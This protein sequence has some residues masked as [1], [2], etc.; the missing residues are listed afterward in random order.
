MAYDTP[1][2][3][4]K[5]YLALHNVPK[6]RCR[7]E[8]TPESAA[9]LAAENKPAVYNGPLFKWPSRK[10]KRTPSPDRDHVQSGHVQSG[11]VQSD[12]QVSS[13]ET[14][15]FVPPYALLDD[16]G[17]IIGGNDYADNPMSDF[18]ARTL[19]VQDQLDKDN[20][21]LQAYRGEVPL[22]FQ[23]VRTAAELDKGDLEAC[24]KLIE[25]TSGDDYKASSMGWKPKKK[26]EEMKDKEM[27]Y[28]LVKEGDSVAGNLLGFISF[29]FT[30]D[31]PPFQSNEVVYIYEVHLDDSL[32]GRG[33]GSRMIRFVEVACHRCGFLKAMLTVFK[34]NAAARGLYEKLGYGKDQCSPED[35]VV[36]GRTIEADYLIMSKFLG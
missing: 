1:E 22:H 26:K 16:N 36:R 24:F 34:S 15:D 2:S 28:L 14:G 21:E 9:R 4:T 11:H 29:M 31:D 30:M 7:W 23:Y 17:D 35:R 6:R 20:I 8:E 32:R 5:A 18:D 27:Q 3:L 19:Y 25:A 12:E 13:E 33:L 10:R